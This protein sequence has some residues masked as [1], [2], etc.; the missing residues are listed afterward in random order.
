MVLYMYMYTYAYIYTYVNI[1]AH[2][3]MHMHT[4]MN[5]NACKRRYLTWV[6]IALL[7][8]THAAPRN[9][10]QHIP[11]PNESPTVKQYAFMRHA[12]S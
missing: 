1:H 12:V 8:W 11:D 5:V 7:A 9:H 10:R 6:L 4:L 2:V 3:Y